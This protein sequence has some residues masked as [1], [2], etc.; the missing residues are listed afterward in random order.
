M[1]VRDMTFEIPIYRKA[2]IQPPIKIFTCVHGMSIDEHQ[3]L[4][5]KNKLVSVMIQG[6]GVILTYLRDPILI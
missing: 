3:R 1:R 5:T 2:Y 6:K 4:P